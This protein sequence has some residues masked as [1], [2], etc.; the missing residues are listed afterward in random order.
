MV[1]LTLRSHECN[2]LLSLF[3]APLKRPGKPIELLAVHPP[4][5]GTVLGYLNTFHTQ[6][7]TEL[8]LWDL[9]AARPT[10]ALASTLAAVPQ[11]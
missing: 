2:P 7:I 10:L 8:T 4:Y 3:Q 11:F 6:N 1:S 9:S 5:L